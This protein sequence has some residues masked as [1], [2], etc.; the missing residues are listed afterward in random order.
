VLI[1][2]TRASDG[3]PR[4]RVGFTSAASDSCRPCVLSDGLRGPGGKRTCSGLWGAFV[5]SGVALC[6]Y[7]ILVDEAAEPVVSADR[8]RS[9]GFEWSGWRVGFGWREPES[10]VRPMAVVVA[11]ELAENV[12]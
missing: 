5:R 8:G 12:L 6:G 7:R 1:A 10:A 4:C 3:L 11:D 2:F 9:L